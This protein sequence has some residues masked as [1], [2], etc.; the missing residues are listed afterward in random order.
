MTTKEQI[1]EAEESIERTLDDLENDTNIRA[2][3]LTVISQR[4]DDASI[5]ITP[6][7]KGGKYQ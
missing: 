3:R 1:R 2:F 4:G 6:D 7:D 5:T